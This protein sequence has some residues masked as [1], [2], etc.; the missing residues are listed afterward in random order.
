MQL[1]GRV[2][3]V[4]QKMPHRMDGRY[5]LRQNGSSALDAYEN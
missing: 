3:V 5:I 4:G 1:G 2:N